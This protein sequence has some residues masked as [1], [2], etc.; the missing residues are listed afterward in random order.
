MSKSKI[1]GWALSGLLGA[2]LILASASGKFTEWE[3]KSEMFAKM[4]WSESVMVKIGV[5]EVI[6]ALLFLVPASAFVGAILLTAYLGGA[7][8]THVRV[9]DPFV[10]P[11]VMGV[12]V[13]VAL[14]LRD[15]RVFA[16]ALGRPLRESNPES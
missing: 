7:V 1:V 5:V 8:S 14:G 13:W 11:I 10:I 9:D 16:L 2:F 3:G 4:G 6:S 12:L 15:C